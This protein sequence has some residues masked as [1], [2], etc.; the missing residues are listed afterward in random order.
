[1]SPQKQV[2]DFSL[3]LKDNDTESENL[4]SL[5]R[6]SESD[7]QKTISL[8]VSFIGIYIIIIIIDSSCKWK[9]VGILISWLLMKPADLDLHCFQTKVYNCVKLC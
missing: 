6:L 8:N 2:T 4:I 9:S 5:I 3:V 7:G 1:M